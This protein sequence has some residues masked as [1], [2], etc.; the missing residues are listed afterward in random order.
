MVYGKDPTGA[1]MPRHAECRGRC[2]MVAP[3]APARVKGQR[4][5]VITAYKPGICT[6]CDLDIVPGDKI[7]YAGEGRYAHRHCPAGVS[8]DGPPRTV[9]M[10]ATR[11]G[12]C[13]GCDRDIIPGDVLAQADG[14]SFHSECAPAEDSRARRRERTRVGRP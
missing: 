14:Q 1:L 4:P 12:P 7:T 2:T 11:P 3:T 8:H 13:A 9:T 10:T 5:V 6:T